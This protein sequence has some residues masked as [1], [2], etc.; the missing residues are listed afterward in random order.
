[1]WLRSFVRYEFKKEEMELKI[2]VNKAASRL[3]NEKIKSDFKKAFVSATNYTP[4]D[5]MI[6]ELLHYKDENGKIVYKKEIQDIF[7]LY[8]VQFFKILASC[9]SDT[10]AFLFKNSFEINNLELEKSSISLDGM[11]FFHSQAMFQKLTD[12][13]FKHYQISDT[14]RD[15]KKFNVEFIINFRK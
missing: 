5:K 9:K 2:D 8:Y 11:K 4:S 12:M 14:T 15:S 10:E 7:T 13:I 6:E 1:M 3:A